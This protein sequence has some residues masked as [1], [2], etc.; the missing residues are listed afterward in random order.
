MQPRWTRPHA[1]DGNCATWPRGPPRT[2]CTAPH[3][4]PRKLPGCMTEAIFIATTLLSLINSK[5]ENRQQRFERLRHCTKYI[6]CVCRQIRHRALRPQSGR[7]VRARTVT[8]R[9]HHA[10]HCS[11]PPVAHHVGRYITRHLPPSFT[12]CNSL[13]SK[14]SNCAFKLLKARSPPTCR[15]SAACEGGGGGPAGAGC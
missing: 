4:T 10:L 11:S 12:P 8:S 2:R 1:G 13:S 6:K 15:R 9:P 5:N 3:P 14:P 7:Q